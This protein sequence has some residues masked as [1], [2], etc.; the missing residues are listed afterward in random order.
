M[1]GF[2]R[3]F[4]GKK[5]DESLDDQL[6][7]VPQKE[8]KTYFLNPDDAKT[9]GDIDY[10]RTAKTIKRT[11]PGTKSTQGK[12]S[13]RIEQ[14]SAMGNVRMSDTNTADASGKPDYMKATPVRENSVQS[15]TT[16]SSSQSEP[17]FTSTQAESRRRTDTNMDMFRNMAKDL[18]RR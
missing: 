17:K 16:A 6:K 9:F 2:I 11:F 8:E 7:A 14:V 15:N 12:G 13:A 10:M 18:K 1:T 4:F 5:K 3:G